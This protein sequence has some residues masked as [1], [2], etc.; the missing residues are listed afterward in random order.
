ME[1]RWAV[2]GSHCPLQLASTR[3]R[4]DCPHRSSRCTR[5][6]GVLFGEFESCAERW[7]GRVVGRGVLP[8]LFHHFRSSRDFRGWK[9]FEVDIAAA[10]VVVVVEVKKLVLD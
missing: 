10:A 9:V 8:V 6:A 5:R 3:G 1:V 4:I 2:F 7:I